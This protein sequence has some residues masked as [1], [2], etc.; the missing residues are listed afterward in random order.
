MRIGGSASSVSANSDGANPV[1]SSGIASARTASEGSVRPT[2]AALI[3]TSAPRRPPESSTPAE[4]ALEARK[5]D[6]GAHG[7]RA[8]GDRT[9]PDLRRVV[10]ADAGEDQRAQSA[11]VDVG[12]DDGNADDGDGRDP[13]AG[14]DDRQR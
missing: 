7:Q 10:V 2:F 3:A 8:G 12:R 6:V 5:R 14:D 4:P 11:G 13:H 1:P 9:G